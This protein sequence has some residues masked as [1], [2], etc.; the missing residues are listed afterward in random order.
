MPI[1]CKVIRSKRKTLSLQVHR[2][3]SIVVRAPIFTLSFQIRSFV[4][5]MQSW[6]EKQQKS[7][8]KMPQITTRSFQNGAKFLVLGEEYPLELSSPIPG[9][10]PSV[11]FENA[12]RIATSSVKQ[13]KELLEKWYRQEARRI[14]T[15]RL[16]YYSKRHNLTYKVLKLSSAK[17]RWGSCSRQKNINL[18]WRLI[19]AP[20]DIIDYVIAHELSHTM[21]MNHSKRFWVQVEEMVPSH[22][23][24][25]KWLKDFGRSLHI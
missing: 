14:F 9:K 18:N 19:M 20:L 6:I 2:D 5:K 24:H 3:G 10:R 1:T 7:F 16:E 12:F 22:K 15:Q 13:G 23:M 21:H 25:K 8:A 11:R 17:T 4:K